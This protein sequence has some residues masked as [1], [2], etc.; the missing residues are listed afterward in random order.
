MVAKIYEGFTV[1]FCFTFVERQRDDSSREPTEAD[2][3]WSLKTHR[4]EGEYSSPQVTLVDWH[5]CDQNINLNYWVKIFETDREADWLGLWCLGT[6][7]STGM[8]HVAGGKGTSSST[9]TNS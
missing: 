5:N 4:K 9:R 8:S 2:A 1:F 7:K 6:L 3:Q